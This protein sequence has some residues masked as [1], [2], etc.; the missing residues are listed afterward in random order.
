VRWL[1]DENLLFPALIG[2]LESKGH[3]VKEAPT[4]V[5]NS[6]LAT[7]AKRED[8]I[9]LTHDKGFANI[10]AY[11]PEQYPGIVRINIHPPRLDLVRAALTQLLAQVDPAAFCGHLIT[12]DRSSYRIYPRSEP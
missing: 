12:L 2:F 1:V 3:E 5:A 6:A 9:L 4:G 8:R 7:L 11:P 10:L